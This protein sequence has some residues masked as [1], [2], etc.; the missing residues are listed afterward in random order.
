MIRKTARHGGAL[1]I[2]HVMRFF[3]LWWI[4][5]GMPA[6]QG[7]YV[8][9]YAAD[10]LGILK[11]E[12]R[13][14]GFIVI[15]EDL[16]TVTG[17]V[18]AALTEAGILSYRVLWFERHPDG[19]FKLPD[20]YPIEA[21]ATTSTHDLPTLAGFFKSRDIEARRA[22]GMI[23]DAAYREQR[24]DREQEIG[25]LTKA[26]KEAG[27]END[28]I[29]FLLSTP[30]VLAIINQEDLTGETDQQNLPGSTWQNPNWR[31]KMKIP[32]EELT[33]VAQQLK[34]LLHASG[35]GH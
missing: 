29:G 12:S 3:R 1:R 21:A 2:D 34:L 28:P 11:L 33:P 13:R 15:G 17:E 5:D 26:L 16:G 10:L 19:T 24:K 9:D 31:R 14:N 32:V 22:A 35:R 18:R 25:R 27:F 6:S 20:E 7:A 4:P 8:R 23:D 30:C